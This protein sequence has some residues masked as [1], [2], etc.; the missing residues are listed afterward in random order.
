M[1]SS[2]IEE[3]GYSFKEM[4]K[5]APGYPPFEYKMHEK[6]L[7][8]NDGGVGFE[9]PTGRIELW[10]HFYNMARLDPLPSFE[11]PMP[12]PVATPE[13]LEEYPLVLTTGARNWS[14]FHSEHRQIPHLRALHPD[15]TIQVNPLT[16]KKYGLKDGDW[17]WVE[18][19]RG[20]CKRKVQ[21]TPIVNERTC[22]TD[23][24]WW[25]PEAPGSLDQGLYGL[26]DMCVGNLIEYN[27]G[28]SGFGAN[29]K[30]LLC[31]IY[32]VEEGD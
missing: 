15:A 22:S 23:H 25:L 26:W 18:N 6:G 9:T 12:G 1:Y 31:K 2:I 8:R 3:T 4:Q 14:L 11:E 32:K 30:T 7:L 16:A 28:K 20:R 10:S 17:C 21:A 5:V 29:Y 27:C 19:Q 24:G 13:L